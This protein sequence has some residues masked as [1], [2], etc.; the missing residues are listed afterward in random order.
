MT[1]LAHREGRSVETAKRTW[2][3]VLGGPQR[4]N[5][6]ALVILVVL[7]IG[8]VVDGWAQIVENWNAYKTDQS[9][10][11][12]L[13]LRIREGVE[14]TDGNRNPLY[15]AILALFAQR[16][17]SFFTAAKLLNLVIATL[18]LLAV[19]WAVKRIS[20]VHA[21]LFTVF[22]L[23]ETD[24]FLESA[25]KTIVEP[26][27]TLIVFATWFLLWKGRGT[28]RWWGLAGVGAGLAYLAKGTGSILP[29]AF[30]LAS[31]LIYGK[32]VFRQRAVWAFLG[33]YAAL[34][35]VLWVNNTLVYGNP[36]YSIHTAH[37]LWLDQWQEKYVSDSS[38]LPTAISYLQTHGLALVAQRLLEGLV[39]VWSPMKEAWF[40]LQNFL[41]PICLTVALTVLVAKVSLAFRK[42]QNRPDSFSWRQ[43]VGYLRTCRE[44]IVFTGVL[45]ILW[46]LFFAWYIPVSDSPR[47]HLPL[48][49]VIQC[50]L[51]SALVLGVRAVLDELPW[52]KG[53]VRA[54]LV[55]LGYVAL[56]VMAI[57]ATSDQ[58]I[59]YI[60]DEKLQDPFRSDR[61]YNADGDAVLE[62]LIAQEDE[63]PV[64]VLYGPSKSLAGL[65][66]Y[67]EDVSHKSIASDLESWD[68]LA[69]LLEED[70]VSWAIVDYEMVD[71]R[72][73]LLGDYFSLDGK[74]VSLKQ[75]PPG[76]VLIHEV[77]TIYGHW[78]IFEI[79]HDGGTASSQ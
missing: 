60:D 42:R 14:L 22:L 46:Y 18:T 16:E 29:I 23:S 51:A 75:P 21:A 24:C 59:S 41:V 68:D 69:D 10:Y 70:Q 3:E 66:R 74:K 71:L 12:R 25:S 27:L 40:P 44:G 31:V 73:E 7:L 28:I 8:F 4:R 62:W 45:L 54:A 33:G 5:V 77:E 64:R 17:W 34:A 13:A 11:M 43:A 2:K 49:P 55:N 35:A 6:A 65:W 37:R 47:F 57:A 53:H 78:F 15:P 67:V 48:S 72:P 79:S 76:W 52:P 36:F 1:V 58:V 20:S 63:L 30:V 39:A 38:Q 61:E 19:Y 9:A 50:G 32:G 26:L 56:A